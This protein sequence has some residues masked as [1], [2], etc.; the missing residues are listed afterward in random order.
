MIFLGPLG[1]YPK[2]ILLS[3]NRKSVTELNV[4]W[5]DPV[6]CPGFNLDGL[7]FGRPKGQLFC[8]REGTDLLTRSLPWDFSY[9]QPGEK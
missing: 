4:I 1:S 7:S 3:W 5:T 8:D 2:S 9:I 6:G